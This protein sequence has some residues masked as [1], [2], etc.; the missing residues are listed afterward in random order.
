VNAQNMDLNHNC[1][2]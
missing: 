1:W 2:L